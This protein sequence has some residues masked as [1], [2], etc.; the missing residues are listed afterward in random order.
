M[1]TDPVAEALRLSGQA[2]GLQIAATLALLMTFCGLSRMDAESYLLG[3][4]N[5]ALAQREPVGK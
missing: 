5:E 2:L 1:P 3:I 4:V